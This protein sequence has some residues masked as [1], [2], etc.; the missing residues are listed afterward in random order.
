MLDHRYIRGEGYQGEGYQTVKHALKGLSVK[1]YIFFL[2]CL[3]INLNA[4]FIRIY[5]KQLVK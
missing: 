5:A 4:L 3:A 2:T 1:V